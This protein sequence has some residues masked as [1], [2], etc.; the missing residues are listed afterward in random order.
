MR[1]AQEHN[2]DKPKP[3]QLLGEI[4]DLDGRMY[5][6]FPA[7]EMKKSGLESGQMV[8]GNLRAVKIETAD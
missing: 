1:I 6:E 8:K 4:V 3:F 5:I 7:D 2:P